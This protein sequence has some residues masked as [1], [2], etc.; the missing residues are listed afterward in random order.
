VAIAK[1]NMALQTT[2]DVTYIQVLQQIPAS[3]GT[4]QGQPTPVEQPSSNGDAWKWGLGIALAVAVA[5][6]V[7]V[8]ATRHEA[9]LAAEKATKKL[10]R[11]ANEGWA[12]MRMR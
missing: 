4:T 10:G 5:G 2:K 3:Q 11:H 7:Y 6:G 8:A 9:K 12:H 1:E